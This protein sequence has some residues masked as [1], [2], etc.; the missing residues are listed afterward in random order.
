MKRK[1]LIALLV[2]VAVLAGLI[3]WK[4]QAERRTRYQGKSIRDW[5][6]ELNRTYEPRGTNAAAVAFRALSSNAVPTLRSLVATREPFYEKLFLQH[7]RKIPTKPRNYLF[8]KLEPG[9]TG[10]IRVGSLQALGIIGPH[11]TAALPE[12][13]AAL[14][15]PDSRLRWTAAQTIT[16]LG[17]EAIAALIPL[18]TNADV[19]LRH[20]AVYSLGEAHT[21]ALPATIP[22]LRN[23]LDT[24]ESVCASAYYSLS[25][26][27]RAALPQV[28]A[29]ADTN[30]DPALRN[31]AL[32]SLIVLTPPPGRVLTSHSQVATNSAEMRRL[33][34]LSL[35][36]S[37]VTNSHAL[38]LFTKALTDDAPDVRA[39]AELAL[40]RIRTGIMVERPTPPATNASPR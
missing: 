31:A 6:V 38:N 28:I 19:N 20:A 9:R 24:N 25:R 16:K 22:L 21:N 32:R 7:A 35:S 27:G 8:Q 2:I 17:P 39:A 15:D 30:A 18:T 26:I 40:K 13:L 23:T 34:I 1:A 12:M 11:A 5:A 37:R 14:A 3:L 33:A 29:T 36:R 10:E 4:Q